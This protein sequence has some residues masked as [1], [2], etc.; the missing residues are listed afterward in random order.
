MNIIIAGLPTAKTQRTV[1]IVREAL[2]LVTCSADVECIYD[3]GAMKRLGVRRTPTV[4]LNARIRAEGRIPSIFEVE[5]WIA[6]EEL[7][8][9]A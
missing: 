6:A 3:V 7:V 2:D 8:T 1:S 4:L 5:S 9:E